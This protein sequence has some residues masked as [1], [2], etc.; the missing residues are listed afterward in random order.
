MPFEKRDF[1]DFKAFVFSNAVIQ[2]L[3]LKVYLYTDGK[4]LIDTASLSLRGNLIDVLTEMNSL[5]NV[6]ITHYHEDHTGNAAF[7]KREKGAAVH[8]PV[9]SRHLT[10]GKNTFKLQPYRLLSWGRP[11]PFESEP[12]PEMFEFAGMSMRAISAPGNSF[13][14]HVFF[15]EE[16]GV[17]FSADLILLP[18]ICHMMDDE[19]LQAQIRSLKNISRLPVRKIFCAHHGV[20]GADIISQKMRFYKEAAVKVRDLR[21]NGASM[22]RII[23]E[24]TGGIRTADIATLWHYS[25]RNFIRKMIEIVSDDALFRELFDY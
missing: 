13:D 25:R 18:R 16:E 14:Q 20:Y 6:Y 17:L 1:G 2:R 21:G 3:N 19:D 8:A 11:E 23:R 15:A 22:G 10:A 4:N 7:L 12:L 9:E 5:Q 24:V